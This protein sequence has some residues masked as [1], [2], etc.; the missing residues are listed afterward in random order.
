VSGSL[1]LFDA[2]N[3]I[4]NGENATNVTELLAED[5]LDVPT[6]F[7]AVTVKVYEVPTDNPDTVIGD[8]PPVPVAPPG[9]AVTVNPVIAE[10]PLFAGALNVTD[11]LVPL[12]AVA[13]PIVGAS[14][15]V[16]PAPPIIMFL[17][18]IRLI[19]RR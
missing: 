12:A 8:E 18:D 15:R 10:P 16:A 19:L 7:V 5:A 1:D 13:V 14:G 3:V 4:E 6:A 9:L 17:I 11:T 2:F